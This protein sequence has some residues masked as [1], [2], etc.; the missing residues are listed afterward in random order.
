MRPCQLLLLRLKVLYRL[1][2]TFYRFFTIVVSVFGG[3]VT[4]VVVV[5]VVRKD[6]PKSAAGSLHGPVNERQLRDVVFVDHAQHW[7]LFLEVCLR[8]LNLLLVRRLKFSLQNAY[9][10]RFGGK[11]LAANSNLIKSVT[12][13]N[14]DK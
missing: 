13:K 10:A 14:L 8:L 7:L 3:P 1:L 9:I 11:R 12:E 4:G 2:S 5:R 6:G